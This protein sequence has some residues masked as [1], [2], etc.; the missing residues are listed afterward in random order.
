MNKVCCLLRPICL[1]S[2]CMDSIELWMIGNAL[3]QS[4]KKCYY[5]IETLWHFIVNACH[6]I[7]IFV[8]PTCIF[9][10]YIA[11]NEILHFIKGQ[12]CSIGDKDIDCPCYLLTLKHQLVFYLKLFQS[13]QRLRLDSYLS[14][15]FKHSVIQSSH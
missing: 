12:L 8:H 2:L 15:A 11:L 7:H 10:S 4:I 14:A 1:A 13:I 3:S 6:H 9:I 5:L